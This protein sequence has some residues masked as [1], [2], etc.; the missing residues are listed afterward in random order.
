[1]AAA[2]D[3]Q[4]SVEAPGK[5]SHLLNRVSFQDCHLAVRA[6]FLDVFRQHAQRLLRRF[7]L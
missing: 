5:R 7:P 2:D 4:V 3:D 1:M 6:G